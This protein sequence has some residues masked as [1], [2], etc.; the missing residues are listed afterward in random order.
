[1]AATADHLNCVTHERMEEVRDAD[2]LPHRCSDTNS[3]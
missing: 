2:F 3:I 1:M